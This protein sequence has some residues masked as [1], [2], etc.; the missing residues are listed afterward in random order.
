M[1]RQRGYFD[2]EHFKQNAHALLTIGKFFD[3]L[4]PRRMTESLENFRFL[5][6]R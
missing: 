5:L 1:P 6:D 2:I 4:K 3:Y